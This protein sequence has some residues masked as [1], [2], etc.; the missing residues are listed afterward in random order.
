M[1]PP[2]AIVVNGAAADAFRL[3]FGFSKR[4][5]QS[6]LQRASR[7]RTV[8]AAVWDDGCDEGA[9]ASGVE[10]AADAMARVARALELRR[11]GAAAA[12]D[13]NLDLALRLLQ[14]S[15]FLDETAE[16]HEMRSQLLD[17]MGETHAAL[18][19]A[20]AATAAAPSW[21]H[22]HW[23]LG[24]CHRNMGDLALAASSFAAAASAAVKAAAAAAAAP[25]S[26]A[27]DVLSPDEVDELRADAKV[28]WRD[29]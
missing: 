26:A 12:E 23:R 27:R 18:Q 24:R 1:P 8:H 25:N 3:S 7:P 22:G 6:K 4:Q 10:S 28:E 16:A 5:P 21:P 17:D 13:G 15:L 9:A 29:V 19:S 11:D 2:S 20:Q 14:N